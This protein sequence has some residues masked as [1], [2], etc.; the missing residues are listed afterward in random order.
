MA[1]SAC[2]CLWTDFERKNMT[3]KGRTGGGLARLRIKEF[4]HS[5][6]LRR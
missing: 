6:R 5:L 4:R 3:G 2:F 1:S